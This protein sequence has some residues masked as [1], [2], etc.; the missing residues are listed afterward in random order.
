MEW[1][2]NKNNKIINQ[3][4]L[5][6]EFFSKIEILFIQIQGWPFQFFSKY[7]VVCISNNPK[8]TEEYYEKEAIFF[9]SNHHLMLL[10]QT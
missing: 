9:S 8:E 4:L 7:S 10:L 5:R 2:K 3:N 6:I 1:M